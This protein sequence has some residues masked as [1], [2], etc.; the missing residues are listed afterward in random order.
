[1]PRKAASEQRIETSYYNAS[2]PEVEECFYLGQRYDAERGFKP[3]EGEC[4]VISH[5]RMPNGEL[6]MATHY[7][8]TGWLTRLWRSPS[9]AL[10]VSSATDSK[11]VF[12]PDLIGDAKRKFDET[13]L[14]APLN[15][16]WGLTDEFVLAWGS[17]FGGT[18]HLY[19]YDG[20]KWK[21]MKAPDFEVRAIH[22]LEEDL[23][24]AVG[25]GGGV[26]RWDGRAWKRFPA[27]TDE[28][29]NSVFMA[30]PDE[31]YATGGAGTLLEGSAHGWGKIA[32]GPVP[33]MPLLAVAKW[34]KDLWVAAGQFG[35]F[36]RVGT[37]NKIKAIKPNMRAVDFETRGK[38]LITCRDFIGETEDGK[39]FDGAGD[40]YLLQQRAG[41]PL[42]KF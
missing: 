16:V 30:G 10:F 42:G 6:G 34:K 19:R 25:V 8:T 33:G 9:G 35:L 21:E 4:W 27:P 3:H 5:R 22:G 18:R 29:L 14:G 36:K 23:L 28:V 38:L 15:G 41:I 1:M 24:Y 37:Q 12:H 26:A 17:T 7:G 31:I 2:G 20:K 32:E 39:E 40:D 13:K 11:V